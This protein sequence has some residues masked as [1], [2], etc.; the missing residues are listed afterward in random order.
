MIVSLKPETERLLREEMASGQLDS[1]DDLI[2]EGIH[3]VRARKDRLRQ[4]ETSCREA[5]QQLRQLRKGVTLG[6]ISGRDLR[7]EGHRY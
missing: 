3:A 7:H 5:A 1:L 2:V 6:G 4:R